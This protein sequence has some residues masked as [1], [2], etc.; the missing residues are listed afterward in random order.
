MPHRITGRNAR[1]FCWLVVLC[2]AVAPLVLS[3][4][5]AAT[6]PV[7]PPPGEN[8]IPPNTRVIH[9]AVRDTNGAPVPGAVVLLK[10]T[11][12]LQIRSYITQSD[13]VY[14]F[15]GLSTDVNYQLRAETKEMTSPSKL[16]SVFDSKKFIKVDLKLKA[17]KKPFPS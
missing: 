11:K 10:D 16:V 14:H 3:Q 15:Y 4:D 9:G 13:G 2:L 17:K 1:R 8:H 12:T 7:V 5:A 6:A